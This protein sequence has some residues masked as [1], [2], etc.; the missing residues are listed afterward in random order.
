MIRRRSTRMQRSPIPITLEVGPVSSLSKR[1]FLTLFIG[2]GTRFLLAL[3]EHLA[4]R[5]LFSILASLVN[6]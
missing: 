4:G 6:N 5:V 2:S 1:D 3:T